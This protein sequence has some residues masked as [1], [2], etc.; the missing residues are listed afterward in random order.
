M[1][2]NRGAMV[3]PGADRRVSLVDHFRCRFVTR[4]PSTDLGDATIL[5]LLETVGAEHRWMH[6]EKLQD[7]DGAAAFS[8]SPI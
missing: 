3:F 6:I 7:F 2:S 1:I 4:D 8:K 5:A